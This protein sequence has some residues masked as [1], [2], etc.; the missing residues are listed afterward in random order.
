[1]AVDKPRKL[2]LHL[3]NKNRQ[4]TYIEALMLKEW[5]ALQRE[6]NGVDYFF[7]EEHAL[8]IVSTPSYTTNYVLG[9]LVHI[10]EYY[11][12]LGVELKLV[13]GGEDL[14]MA[15]WYWD[16]LLSTQLTIW[17]FGNAM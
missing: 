9:T 10:M 11:L 15:Y 14:L 5:T 3:L 2:K 13:N 4:R 1:M 7:R 12:G 6:A 16:F 17:L 8:K